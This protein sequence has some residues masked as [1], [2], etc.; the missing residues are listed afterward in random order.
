MQDSYL[1][2]AAALGIQRVIAMCSVFAMC[3][4]WASCIQYVT[5]LNHPLDSSEGSYFTDGTG[6]AWYFARAT[7]ILKQELRARSA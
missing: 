7:Q 4:P 1:V 2:R 6:G 3:R 5:S